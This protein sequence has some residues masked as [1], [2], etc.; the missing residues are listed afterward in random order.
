MK[1]LLP[2]RQSLSSLIPP[3][4][5]LRLEMSNGQP[6]ANADRNL[7]DRRKHAASRAERSPESHDIGPVP[8]PHACRGNAQ[9]PKPV[10]KR[11]LG[12]ERENEDPEPGIA[13]R[14][15][16]RRPL[17]L[18]AP[19]GRQSRR[20]EENERALDLQRLTDEDELCPNERTQR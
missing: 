12:Y 8:H 14:G 9:L 18:G 17:L 15:D 13:H 10:E 2:R 3:N 4:S 19:A 11:S 16:Q 1:L 5:S 20:D 7:G 6:G